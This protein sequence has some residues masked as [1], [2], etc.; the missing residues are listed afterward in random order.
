MKGQPKFDYG[1]LVSFTIDDKEKVG[2]VYI[3]DRY[4]TFSDGSDVS[5]DIMVE[6]E[7]T[8]YKHIGEKGVNKV[9]K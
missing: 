2:S 5:Y 1:D 3:I 7:N 6:Q 9:E 4:G 8:L